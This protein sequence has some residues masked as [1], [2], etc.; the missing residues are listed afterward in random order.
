MED[1][2]QDLPELPSFPKLIH[3]GRLTVELVPAGTE[4]S[5][6][7]FVQATHEEGSFVWWNLEEIYRLLKG[8]THVPWG[9]FRKDG[10]R[11]WSEMMLDV[12]LGKTSLLQQH[13]RRA[14]R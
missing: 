13:S 2:R 6:S 14:R 4:H 10:W 3:R 1:G 12:G 9:E 8:P 7:V 11:S 5:L